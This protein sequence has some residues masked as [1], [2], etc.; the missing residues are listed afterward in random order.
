MSESRMQARHRVV[1]HQQWITSDQR[2]EKREGVLVT[3]H[4]RGTAR[5]EKVDKLCL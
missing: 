2:S 5:L 1:S 4:G 3:K